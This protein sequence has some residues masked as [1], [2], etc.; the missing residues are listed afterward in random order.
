MTS[1]SV[2][3]NR[4]TGK[5]ACSDSSHTLHR[6]PSWRVITRN[7]KQ[8]LCEPPTSEGAASAGKKDRKRVAPLSTTLRPSPA[9][10]K[11]KTSIFADTDL[12]V[13]RENT[14]K[15]LRR[16]ATLKGDDEIFHLLRWLM[17]VSGDMSMYLFTSD[18]ERIHGSRRRKTSV[19]RL[20]TNLLS[21]YSFAVASSCQARENSGTVLRRT[22]RTPPEFRFDTRSARGDEG[23]R[24]GAGSLLH[25][26]GHGCRSRTRTS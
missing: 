22:N 12:T 13:A 21:R 15:L 26:G 3:E 14:C 24:S 9:S 4:I 25:E 7:S 18:L 23:P 17:A 8:L 1:L 6:L 20:T 2:S 5:L 11:A 10:E 16:T 19:C